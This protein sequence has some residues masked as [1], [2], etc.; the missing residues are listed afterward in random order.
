MGWLFRMKRWAQNP[1]STSR[2]IMVLSIV[3]ICLV[4]FA[5]E[6][7]IGWPEALS[8]EVRRSRFP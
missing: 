8:P 7:F 2:V 5:I 4:L 1:P 3:A 6:R